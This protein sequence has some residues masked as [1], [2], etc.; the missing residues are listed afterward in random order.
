[1]HLAAYL[2]LP[3]TVSNMLKTGLFAPNIEDRYG[4]TPLI[5]AA[6]KGNAA[7]VKVL[8]HRLD[9]DVNNINNR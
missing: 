6:Y 3:K 9:V 7:T 4:R 2:D 5:F 1:M 8:L